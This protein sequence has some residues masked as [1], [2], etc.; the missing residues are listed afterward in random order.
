MNRRADR[1]AAAL[2]A[3]FPLAEVEVV[4]DSHRH[5]GHAGAA[6]GGET[7]YNVRVVSPAFA[8]MNRVARSRAAHEA[9][10]AEFASGLHALALT[11]KTPEEMAA[12]R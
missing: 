4:D 11:L 8:G 1:I 3:A 6:P 5:A 12:A 2:A 7:H 10:A 9:L